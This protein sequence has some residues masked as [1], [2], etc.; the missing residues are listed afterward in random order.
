MGEF[1]RLLESGRI[2]KMALKNRI[3]FPPLATLMATGDG[4]ITDQ[5]IDYY[6]ERAGGG[7]GLVV[8]EG[9]FPSPIGHPNRIALE[10]HRRIPGLRKLVAAVHQEGAKVVIEVNT[11]KGRQD[12]YPLSPS[13]VPHPVTG[14]RPR[15]ATVADIERLKTEYGEAAR[16]VKEAGFDGIMIHGGTGYLVAEFLSPL[17]NRR[18]DEYGGDVRRRARFALE[19]VEV[20][21]EKVGPDYPIIFRLMSHDRA[22]GG[23]DTEE[24]VAISRMLEGHGVDAIDVTT[25][26]AVSHEWTTPPSWLPAGCNADVSAAIKK[27]MK[28]PVSVAGKIN[29]PYLAERILAEGKA[30]FVDIGRGLLADP[31]FVNKIMEGRAGEIRKCI[32]C[33]RCG[34]QIALSKDPIVC[35]VN[36]SVGREKEFRS[37]MKSGG[38]KKKVLVIGGGPAGMEAAITA[39]RRGHE[40]G[41]WE[42]MDRLGGNLN[43]AIIPSGKGDMRDLL[44]YLKRQLEGS[45]VGLS[46]GREAT[47]ESIREFAPDAVILAV[48]S[49]PFVV[50]IPGIA[51]ENVVG[52]GEVLLGRRQIADKNIV[53]WGA[54]FVACEVACFLAE[55][56]KEV[57]M[58]FPE[59]DLLPDVAYPMIRKY[60]LRK[61]EENKVRIV[62]GVSRF[63]EITSR[64]I[65]LAGKEEN[66]LFIEAGGIVLATGVRPDKILFHRL[67]DTVPEIYEAGDCVEPR[68][69]MEAIREGAEVALNV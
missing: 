59:I 9:S 37:K 44:V 61:L 67:K 14:V 64:G 53:V 17:V 46:L 18:T 27:G 6:A 2:G 24:A 63:Q 43:L 55:K 48:G 36:P 4:D 19:L 42:K 65:R 38:K 66:E 39:D 25:G 35:T 31:Q 47:V 49:T 50:N 34:E 15:P 54:G 52:F 28:I 5:Q 23:L 60:L 21:R 58:V 3:L 16:R 33:L 20:T 11:H 68:R 13:D 29:D 8:I 7:V 30:D 32:T 22:P 62:P 40:V 12:Q 41:L 69:L 51:G 1:S 57:T 45:H 56:G 26:S 10:H